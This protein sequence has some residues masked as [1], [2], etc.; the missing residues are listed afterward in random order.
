MV[1]APLRGRQAEARRNDDRIVQA[2][3]EVMVAEGAGASMATIAK[4]AGVGVA[5]LY[6]R[7]A[8]KEDLIREVAI[9]G[10]RSIICYAREAAD[11]PDAWQAFESFMRRCAESG[12]GALVQLAGHF[13]PNE[14]H[15]AT[16]DQLQ[17]ALRTLLRRAKE[18]GGIRA[19]ITPADICLLL[20]QL[21]VQHPVDAARTPQLRSRHLAILIAGLRDTDDA[22]LPGPAPSWRELRDFWTKPRQ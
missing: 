14:E 3:R 10:M 6:A 15:L 4:R 11:E 18:E 2:A 17:D 22:A 5:S 13:V 7:Y 21:Q 16:V 19:G 12:E 8:S 20:T 9:A 1:T